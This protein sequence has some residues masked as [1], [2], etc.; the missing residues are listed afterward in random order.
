MKKLLVYEIIFLGLFLLM[1][2]T[3]TSQHLMGFLPWFALMYFLANLSSKNIVWYIPLYVLVDCLV[4]FHTIQ[5]FAYAGCWINYLTL[6][7][8]AVYSWMFKT[9]TVKCGVIKASVLSLLWFVLS[10]TQSWIYLRDFY[11]YDFS[12][13]CKA[14]VAGIPFYKFQYLA[15]IVYSFVFYGLYALYRKSQYYAKLSI[16]FK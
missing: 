1:L 5:Q 11:S 16:Y 2:A 4:T 7:L 13:W 6:V 8:L 15:D 12:G 10:N 14:I 9:Q 3:R